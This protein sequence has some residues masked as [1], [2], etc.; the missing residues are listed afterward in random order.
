MS[1]E[2]P[3]ANPIQVESFRNL[4]LQEFGVNLTEEEARDVAQRFL[5][6]YFLFN[7]A[8]HPI[9]QKK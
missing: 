5:N 2:L 9:L 3:L 6:L 7:H 4:Y 1:V 8:I